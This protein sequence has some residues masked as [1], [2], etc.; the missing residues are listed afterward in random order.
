[1]CTSAEW[2]KQFSEVLAP[3]LEGLR[4]AAALK[5]PAALPTLHS[6]SHFEGLASQEEVQGSLSYKPSTHM[7]I[8]EDANWTSDSE[9]EGT[10]HKS[11]MLHDQLLHDEWHSL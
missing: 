6:T 1:M 10:P 11:S 5:K 7:N 9:S 8:A 3:S 4:A 2:D